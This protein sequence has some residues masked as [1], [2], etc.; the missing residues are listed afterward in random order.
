MT[1]LP[2]PTITLQILDSTKY[3]LSEL[4]DLIDRCSQPSF[5]RWTNTVQL[6]LVQMI[7][8]RP[9][10]ESMIE[11][12]N[13]P[14]VKD[15]SGTSDKEFRW[16]R[17]LIND[18]EFAQRHITSSSMDD[19]DDE[20]YCTIDDMDRLFSAIA[21]RTL[22]VSINRCSNI[23]SGFLSIHHLDHFDVHTLSINQKEAL[24]ALKAA[25][26][27][28]MIQ[29]SI[30]LRKLELRLPFQG[31]ARELFVALANA[32][33]IQELS[34]TDAWK[35]HYQR[36]HL[37]ALLFGDNRNN[38]GPV[39]QLLRNPQN[40]LRKLGLFNMSLK[41]HHLIMLLPMIATSQ[42]ESLCVSSNVI[43]LQGML[44]FASFLPRMPTLK[45][46]SF[47]SNPWEDSSEDRKKVGEALLQG[48][49][50]NLSIETV[51][52]IAKTPQAPRLWHYVALNRAG[53]RILASSSQPIADGL[54]PL[55]LER[56]GTT[57]WY[58]GF[59][60]VALDMG[61]ERE[62]DGQANAVYYFLQNC[63]KIMSFRLSPKVM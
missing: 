33:G 52:G 50:G 11:L 46:V 8:T 24:S 44:E 42:I 28:D 53:R 49:I 17:V 36:K 55:V 37:P 57:L 39:M 22:E 31:G 6:W 9:L 38:N 45:Y 51:N 20:D 58:W 19:E 32:I 59:N 14:L 48:M 7:I 63:P 27:G 16:I 23:V 54:W 62:Y 12:L 25:K 35:R 29:G 4:Y 61:D 21:H 5:D 41:D 60:Q 56:A 26:L 15:P 10:L 43:Q 40:Q 1:K 30:H 13:L 34:L 47:G 2:Y 3:P 18:C